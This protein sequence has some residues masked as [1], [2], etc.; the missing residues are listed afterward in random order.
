MR[1]KTEF[2]VFA[3]LA[4][5]GLFLAGIFVGR[6]TQ[7]GLVVRGSASS[8]SDGTDGLPLEQAAQE[9]RAFDLTALPTLDAGVT[10][11]LDLNTASLE[12][13]CTLPGIGEARAGRIIAYREQTGGFRSVDELTQIEGIGQGLLDD[14]IDYVT[15]R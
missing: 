13:L 9:S 5:L 3:L 12:E 4:A 6:R 11:P 1:R 2:A 10:Y 8:Q 7:R 14:I 15:V